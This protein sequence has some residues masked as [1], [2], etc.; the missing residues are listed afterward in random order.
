MCNKRLLRCPPRNWTDPVTY[1]I[2][3]SLTGIKEGH[4]LAGQEPWQCWETLRKRKPVIIRNPAGRTWWIHFLVLVPLSWSSKLTN[5]PS[6]LC[7]SLLSC[8]S[9]ISVSLGHHVAV[10]GPW[11]GCLNPVSLSFLICKM[12]MK[13]AP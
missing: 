1:R 3:P 7:L 10:A 11:V 8:L 12:R 5:S 9:L 13:M 4:F 6:I 2:P